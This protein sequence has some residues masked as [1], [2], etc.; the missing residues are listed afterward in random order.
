MACRMRLLRMTIPSEFREMTPVEFLSSRLPS[1]MLRCE[2]R[3]LKARRL[4]WM[5]LPVKRLRGELLT[6]R[7][8]IWAMSLFSMRLPVLYHRRMPSP[9]SAESTGRERMRLP[10]TILSVVLCSEMPNSTSSST[11]FSISSSLPSAMMAPSMVSCESPL[12]RRVRPRIV[13][14]SALMVSTVPR[15]PASTTTLPLPSTVSGLLMMAGP[16]Y[17]PG[18]RRKVVPGSAVSSQ[19]CS[20]WLARAGRVRPRIGRTKKR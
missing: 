7:S 19:A 12:P 11:L 6:V 13:T 15:P 16:R 8:R 18:G 3:K 1:T 20:G 14:R 10:R 17:L 4:S 5:V 9:R 2:N